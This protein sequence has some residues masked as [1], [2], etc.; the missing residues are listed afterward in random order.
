M[1]QKKNYFEF[2]R[3]K[4]AAITETLAALNLLYSFSRYLAQ[5]FLVE[6]VSL[7]LQIKNVNENLFYCLHFALN[8]RIRFRL[9]LTSLH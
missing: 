3:Q 4:K 9:T 1:I 5:I 7:A 2:L 6:K 8:F